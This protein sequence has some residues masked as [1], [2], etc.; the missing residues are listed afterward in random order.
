MRAGT[1]NRRVTLQRATETVMPS[2]SVTTAWTELKT[3]WA[4][5]VDATANEATAGFAEAETIK[6][7][8]RIRWLPDV[9]ITTADRLTYAG[10]AYNIRDVHEIGW[11]VGLELRC[12]RIRQ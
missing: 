1:L 8:F 2:G 4:E 3:V 7:T 12:E 11:R 10:G 5:L 6:R 9:E